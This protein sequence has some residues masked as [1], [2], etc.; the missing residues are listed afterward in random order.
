MKK[1]ERKK[2]ERRETKKQESI[3]EQG[4]ER[5]DLTDSIFIYILL[6]EYI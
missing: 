4:S 3:H 1:E 2:K 6:V 5:L